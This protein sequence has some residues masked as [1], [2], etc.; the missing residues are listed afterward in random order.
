MK[1][2]TKRKKIC[3][4]LRKFCH[5]VDNNYNT[6]ITLGPGTDHNNIQSNEINLK[7]TSRRQFFMLQ[8]FKPLDFGICQSV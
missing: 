8:D 2:M 5:N 7:V 3:Q 4:G 6:D 1:N